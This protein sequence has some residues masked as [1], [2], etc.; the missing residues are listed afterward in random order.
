MPF[1]IEV[2]TPSFSLGA[3]ESFFLATPDLDLGSL[4]NFFDESAQLADLPLKARDFH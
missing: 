3:L 4:E 2:E 1:L